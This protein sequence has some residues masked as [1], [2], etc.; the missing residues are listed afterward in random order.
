MYQFFIDT[1][2][3]LR[4]QFYPKTH[5]RY[6]P[7]VFIAVLLAL[8]LMSIANMSPFLGHQSGISAFIMVLT[9][10]RWAVLSFSMQS[11]LSYYNRQPGQ[12]YGYILVTEALTLPMVAILYFP[13]ALAMPGM[14]WMIWTIVV[15]VG[16]FVRISQQNVFKVALAYIVYCFITCLAGS[17]ILLIFS[18]MGW[19]DLNTMAQSFQQ[20]VTLP[21][22]EN[23]LR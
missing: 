20:M 18:G 16:G 22:A 9:V 7:F 4:M 23:G 13:H 21:A 1:W 12:W 17:V 5:Y 8:G 2:A 14:A 19:L 10:L 11:I 6:S 15:Q 3:A